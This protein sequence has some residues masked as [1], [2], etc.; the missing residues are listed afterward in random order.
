MTYWS[1]KS[2][3]KGKYFVQHT[4]DEQK[5]SIHTQLILETALSP[6]SYGQLEP[7]IATYLVLAPVAAVFNCK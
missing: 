6:V 4:L 1:I 7:Y 2:I 3:N 5:F